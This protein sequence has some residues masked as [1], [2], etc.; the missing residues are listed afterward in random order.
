[1]PTFKLRSIFW[2]TAC[3]AFSVWLA[4]LPPQTYGLTLYSPLEEVWLWE[5]DLAQRAALA[6]AFFIAP[7]AVKKCMHHLRSH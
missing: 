2:L 6:F 1:M 5:Y 7:I 4:L 3:V